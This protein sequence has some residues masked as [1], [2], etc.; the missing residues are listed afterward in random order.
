MI[1]KPGLIDAILSGQKTQTRRL[2]KP[3]EEAILWRMGSEGDYT[4]RE[5]AALHARPDA[6]GLRVYSKWQ[7]GRDYAV[8]PKRGQP[9]VWWRSEPLPMGWKP[10][11]TAGYEKIQ[12]ALTEDGFRPLRIRITGIRRE[13]LQSITEADA[14]AEGVDSVEAYRA[15]WDRINGNTKGARWADNPPVW[16]ITFEVVK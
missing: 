1:F 12:A 2:V 4:L 10:P 13:A 7:V 15:L 8:V 16:V 14:L 5:V 3:G 9:G 11:W 6:S